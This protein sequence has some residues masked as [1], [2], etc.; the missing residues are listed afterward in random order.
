MNKLIWMMIPLL[1]AGNG[2]TAQVKRWKFRECLDTALVHNITVNQSRLTNELNKVSL[3][4]SKAGRIP[5]VSANASEGL[6]L[7]KNVDPTTNSFVT[8]AYHSTNL[9][10]N[11]SYNLFNGLQNANT[12][13]QNRLNVEAGQYDIEKVKNDVTLNI[14]TGYLQVLFAYEVLSAAKNQA[15]VTAA[16]VD[17]TQKM[18][19]AGKSPE[20]DLLQIR[21]QQATDNL[22]VI[23]AQNQLDLAKVTLMQLMEIPVTDLFDVEIPTMLE[24]TQQILNTNEEIYRRSLAVMPQITGYTIKTDAALM[25]QKVSEGARWPRLTLGANLNTNFASSRTQGSVVNP[26]GYPFFE[27]IWD[28]IGQSLN[29][30]LSIPI[31]SNRQIKSNIDRAKI[32]VLNARLNEQNVKNVLR[33][34][35][36]QTATDLKA[37]S[38]KY[39]AT[40]EQLRAVEAAYLNAEKKYGVGVMNATDFLIQKNNFFQSQSN[41][42]QAKYDYIFKSKILDFYQGKD[43]QIN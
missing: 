18:V 17:R 31:Y 33:K 27:Q 16:Q 28:N 36:E 19:E 22:S 9:S 1:L 39:E 23:T 21:S 11:G 29:L 8:Q 13:R 40:R 26:E 2:V 35:V 37:A 6:S 12:I 25:A 4:Q 15:E 30:G 5:S 42:I 34:N 7:G 43:I 10:I 32:N 3:E 24:P 41:L 20:S 38:K 14:T